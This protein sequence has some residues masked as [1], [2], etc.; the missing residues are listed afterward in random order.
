MAEVLL[1]HELASPHSHL[2]TRGSRCPCF[3]LVGE[4]DLPPQQVAALAATGATFLPGSAW[5]AGQGVRVRIGLPRHRWNGN[6]DV[7][8]AFDCGPGCGESAAALMRYD[9]S[10]WRVID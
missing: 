4:Q 2:G 1:R 5:S 10:R 8:L 9:G 6:F 7:A 3:V